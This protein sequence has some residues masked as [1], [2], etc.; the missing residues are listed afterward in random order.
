MGGGGG[1]V[2]RFSSVSLLFKEFCLVFI[3]IM[4]SEAE[5]LDFK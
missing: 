4:E 1:R 2:G 5:N 3:V